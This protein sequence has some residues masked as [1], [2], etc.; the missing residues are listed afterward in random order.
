MWRE[1]TERG[2]LVWN[3]WTDAMALFGTWDYALWIWGVYLGMVVI[4]GVF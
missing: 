3:A 2:V 4:H 1:F